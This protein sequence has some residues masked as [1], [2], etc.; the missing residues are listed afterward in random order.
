M[1]TV[2]ERPA[3]VTFLVLFAC[4]LGSPFL[5]FFLGQR[6]AP[7]SDVAQLASIFAF[8]LSFFGGLVLWLGLGVLAVVWKGLRSLFRGRAPR[9]A[10]VGKSEVLVPPGYGSFVF[11][12]LLFCGLAGLM[13]G[14][15][16]STSVLEALAVYCAAGAF[17]GFALRLLAHHGYLP[18]PEP[19]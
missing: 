16:S 13:V 11:L 2:P 18:F 1:R 9:A 10:R 6:F 3:I 7:G 14:L 12:S 5:G 17:Y 4:F 15:L 19:E 8:P